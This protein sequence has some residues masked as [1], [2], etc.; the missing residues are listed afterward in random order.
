MAH[1]H[2]NGCRKI[3][4]ADVPSHGHRGHSPEGSDFSYYTVVKTSADHL[5]QNR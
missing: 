1:G 5:A 3:L 2:S 4:V